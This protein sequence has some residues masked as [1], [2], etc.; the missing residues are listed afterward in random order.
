MARAKFFLD[1]RPQ[2]IGGL[3]FIHL[4][5][6]II[7]VTIDPAEANVRL[8]KNYLDVLPTFDHSKHQH[9]IEDQYCHLHEVTM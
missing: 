5:V 4:V 3:F 1:P 7:T 9:I 8:K 6:R 2:V